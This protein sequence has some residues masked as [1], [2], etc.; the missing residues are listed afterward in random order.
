M[1]FVSRQ[2][3]VS[4]SMVERSSENLEVGFRRQLVGHLFRLPHRQGRE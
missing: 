1:R 4:R 2:Y 3:G